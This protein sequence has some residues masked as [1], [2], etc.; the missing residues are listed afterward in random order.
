MPCRI[1][2][3]VLVEVS[4]EARKFLPPTKLL[5]RKIQ[6]IRRKNKGSMEENID[7]VVVP[8]LEL[9]DGSLF[10]LYDNEK[11]GDRLIILGSHRGLKVVSRSKILLTDGTFKS[12]PK[13]VPNIC[14][15]C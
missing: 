11:P 4:D 5:K 9:P 8:T 6:H 12:A 13:L 2:N 3:D 15:S 14:N 10:N 1:Q 7:D